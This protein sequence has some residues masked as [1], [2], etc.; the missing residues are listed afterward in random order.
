MVSVVSILQN[1][2]SKNDLKNTWT[3][4]LFLDEQQSPSDVVPITIA[5]KSLYKVPPPISPHHQLKYFLSGVVQI[6]YKCIVA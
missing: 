1:I 3:K 4:T 5:K 6:Y 2:N